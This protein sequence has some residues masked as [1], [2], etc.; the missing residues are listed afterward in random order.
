MGHYSKIEGS[1]VYN[2]VDLIEKNQCS[3]ILPFFLITLRLAF[4][5][6]HDFMLPNVV[7]NYTISYKVKIYDGD[8]VS[9]TQKQHEQR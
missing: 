1:I 4:T 2:N 7:V 9:Y 8:I 6:L 3:K 5:I